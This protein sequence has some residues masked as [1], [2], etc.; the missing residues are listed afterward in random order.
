MTG[1]QRVLETFQQDAAEKEAHHA[2][3]ITR[4]RKELEELHADSVSTLREELEE[5]YES[6]VKA[7]ADDHSKA[8]DELRQ[9]LSAADDVST[10][11]LQ[12]RL[13]DVI[14]EK[15][16]L[17]KRL[18]EMEEAQEA[19]MK[20]LTDDHSKAID[21]LR[22]SLPAT[23]SVSTGD[24][25]RRLSDVISEKDHLEKRLGDVEFRHNRE[26]EEESQKHEAAYR[27]LQLAFAQA[28]ESQT[29][30]LNEQAKKQESNETELRETMATLKASHTDAVEK[31]SAA[32]EQI[33]EEMEDRH[34]AQIAEMEREAAS[35]VVAVKEEGDR[36]YKATTAAL[37]AE[38]DAQTPTEQETED[39][40][41]ALGGMPNV[42]GGAQTPQRGLSHVFVNHADD[43]MEELRRDPKAHRSS[44]TPLA[45]AS[46]EDRYTSASEYARDGHTDGVALV[47]TVEQP[48]REAL[49]EEN[50]KLFASLAAAQEELAVLRALPASEEED[51]SPPQQIV[52]EEPRLEDPFAP[53]PPRHQPNESNGH[54]LSISPDSTKYSSTQMTLEGTLESLRVQ[55]EQLLEVQDDILADNRRFSQKLGGLRSQRNSPFR[56]SPL[57]AAS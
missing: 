30:Q 11:D 5:A 33:V 29:R 25:Q 38:Y 28:K 18:E 54:S 39:T 6:E 50:A 8:I 56:S 46:D 22:Q 23:D 10:G 53:Q 40:V 36:I 35:R 49:E 48:T 27:D 47:S 21:G 41:E 57:R 31:L 24:L 4:L 42:T 16:H 14:L 9:S 52:K 15:E 3:S 19:N 26:L 43:E 7:L 34:A 12:R 2:N 20:T 1:L 37:I 44:E 45:Y 55:T 32:H 17:E 13:S 51:R